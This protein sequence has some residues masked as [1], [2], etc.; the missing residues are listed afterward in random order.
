MKKTGDFFGKIVV[1]SGYIRPMQD[2]DGIMH[3]ALI[4]FLLEPEILSA[5]LG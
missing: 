4:P 5:T 1:R 2:D 3:V